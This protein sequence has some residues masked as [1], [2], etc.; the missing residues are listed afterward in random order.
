M[1]KNLNIRNDEIST[2]KQN[3]VKDESDPIMKSNKDFQACQFKK[4]Q[5]IIMN[6]KANNK[7][8]FFLHKQSLEKS[9]QKNHNSAN[10]NELANSDQKTTL[11]KDFSMPK[12]INKGKDKIEN[13]V[14][15]KMKHFNSKENIDKTTKNSKGKLSYLVNAKDNLIV[16]YKNKLLGINSTENEIIRLLNED[17]KTYSF[18]KIYKDEEV[19]LHKYLGYHIKEVEIDEDYQTDNEMINTKRLKKLNSLRMKLIN[20]SKL[21]FN[22]LRKRISNLQYQKEPFLM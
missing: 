5:K 2:T 4:A 7:G 9:F 8:N 3:E 13:N 18:F 17:N 10:N 11:A 16:T 1:T 19:F 14:D 22:D 20:L 21:D 6:G 12:K 15:K